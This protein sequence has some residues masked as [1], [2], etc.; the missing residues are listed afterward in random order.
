MVVRARVDP[1]VTIEKYKDGLYSSKM[2]QIR[3]EE[4]DKM[5]KTQKKCRELKVFFEENDNLIIP[6]SNG[7]IRIRF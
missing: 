5:S 6:T 4:W 1:L 7:Y 2:M 3:K